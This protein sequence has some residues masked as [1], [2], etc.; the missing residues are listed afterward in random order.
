M[1]VPYHHGDFGVAFPIVIG[2]LPLRSGDPMPYSS[3]EPS[4]T[5]GML[6]HTVYHNLNT[7]Y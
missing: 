4:T 6:V 5:N 1:N 2:T 7:D 3:L